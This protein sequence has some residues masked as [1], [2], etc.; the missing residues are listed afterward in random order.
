VS[1]E[2]SDKQKEVGALYILIPLLILHLALLSLQIEDTAGASLF[3]TWV[4]QIVA[5]F[6]RASSAATRG[7]EYVWSSYLWLYGARQENER[8]KTELQQLALRESGRLQVEQENAR[9]SRLLDFKAGLSRRT[10]GARVVGRTPDF[11]S[12]TLYVDRGTNDGVTVNAPVLAG[13]AV[14]GRT[15]VVTPDMSQVQLITNADAAVGAMVQSSR[16]PG[17][18]SGNGGSLLQMNYIS[19]TEQVRLN[20]PVV[21]SGLDGIFPKG[22]LIGTV[23]ESHKGNSV[24]RVVRVQPATDLLHVEEVLIL[25]AEPEGAERK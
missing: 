17:V 14:L 5:P 25:L 19:N 3:K 11:L 13:G 21:T 10:T 7:V 22:L 20:E 8:L 4:V 2:L 9:L 15:I 24:F 23:V 12:N 6:M 18:A 16:S 1:I